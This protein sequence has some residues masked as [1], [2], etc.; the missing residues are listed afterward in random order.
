MS[1]EKIRFKIVNK[2]KDG[3]TLS[4]RKG[5]KPVKMGW[6]EFDRYYTIEDKVWAVPSEEV[7]N[8][9][10]EV[11]QC[12]IDAT[13]AFVCSGG[14]KEGTQ[15]NANDL[16]Y[17]LTLND[18]ISRIAEL[19]GCTLQEATMLVKKKLDELKRLPL[20]NFEVSE[21]H[22]NKQR[23]RDKS[24]ESVSNEYRGNTPSDI[25]IGTSTI[26]EDNPTLR[27]LKEKFQK[28]Q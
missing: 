12:V 28:E 2:A 19:T 3:I 7:I 18:K 24:E 4:A 21:H 5:S 26:L 16:A 10:N 27:A 9:M 13:I 1:Q 11:E 14:L 25:K 8:K 23:N 6:D 20:D 22:H 15:K 17:M